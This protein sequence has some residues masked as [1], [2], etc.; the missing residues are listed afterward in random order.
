MM[1]CVSCK[2]GWGKGCIT[3]L[4]KKKHKTFLC[5][6]MRIGYLEPLVITE[7]SVGARVIKCKPFFSSYLVAKRGVMIPGVLAETVETGHKIQHA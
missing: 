7:A 6:R 2:I 1:H 5:I 4:K 3:H